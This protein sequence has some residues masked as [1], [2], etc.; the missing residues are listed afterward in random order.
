MSVNLDSVP[1]IRGL[2]TVNSST[3]SVSGSRTNTV[4]TDLLSLQFSSPHHSVDFG[5]GW[6]NN[7][8]QVNG[9]GPETILDFLFR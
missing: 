1:W 9:E 5:I 2:V 6:I 3:L 7:R 8:N 4:S